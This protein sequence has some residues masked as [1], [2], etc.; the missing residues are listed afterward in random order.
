MLKIHIIGGPGS[1]KT[2]LAAALSS[3][4]QISH[5]DLDLIGR[6]NGMD[7]EAYV[8]DAL[9]IAGQPGWVTENIGLVWIDPLLQRA[10]YIVLLEVSWP[11][12][13]YR[14]I[15][16]H[17]TKSLQGTNLYP[18]IKSLFLFLQGTREYYLNTC[19]A[20]TAE[21]MS[22][23]LE[24]HEE[25]VEPLDGAGLRAHREKY[26]LEIMIAPTAEFVRRYLEKYKE[27]VI[28]VKNNAD[29]KRL[30]EFLTQETSSSAL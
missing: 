5:Y 21:L 29:R 15:R 1:G 23:Y 30:L 11:V 20:S 16:R 7:D 17:V 2:T 18:G 4:F 3:R 9:A 22:R 25:R 28:V 10:D 6:K 8:E 19:S 26:G 24:E 27:K 12:A 14:I 13:A